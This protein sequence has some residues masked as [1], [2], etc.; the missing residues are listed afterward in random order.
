MTAHLAGVPPV[1]PAAVEAA[2]E[3][4][5]SGQCERTGSREAEITLL[6][7]AS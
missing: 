7:V 5:K 2:C 3:R 6:K 1:L 4:I